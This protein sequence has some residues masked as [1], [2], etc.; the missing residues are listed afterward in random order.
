[1]S[2]PSS[3]VSHPQFGSLR[4]Q[5]SSHPQ[6]RSL[7]KQASSR[8]QFGSLRKQAISRKDAKK[9]ES[10]SESGKTKLYICVPEPFVKVK[11]LTLNL[12]RSFQFLSYT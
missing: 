7:R 5:L 4:K 10:A 9:Q 3:E 2:L 6:F 8:P 12:N 1:V 11:P